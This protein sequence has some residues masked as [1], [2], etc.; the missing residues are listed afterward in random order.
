MCRLKPPVPS[1]CPIFVQND[2]STAMCLL[3]RHVVRYLSEMSPPPPCASRNVALSDICPKCELRS[4]VPYR[5]V[6]LSDICPKCNLHR[7]V[8]PVPCVVRISIKMRSPQPF[9]AHS[10]ISH[11]VPS[12]PYRRCHPGG[13]W[14]VC[15]PIIVLNAF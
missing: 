3:Y 10:A 9:A 14:G 2:S 8:P 4:H 1:R 5:T 15:C 12:L 7:C 6:A 11:I 13:A